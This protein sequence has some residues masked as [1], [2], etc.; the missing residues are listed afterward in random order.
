MA[1]AGEAC[2]S[3]SKPPILCPSFCFFILLDQRMVGTDHCLEV[4]VIPVASARE[5]GGGVGG[6]EETGLGNFLRAAV[7]SPCSESQA[8][9]QGDWEPVEIREPG[10]LQY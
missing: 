8:L 5:G 2:P 9:A 3:P 4:L 6:R 1:S 10:K 7:G